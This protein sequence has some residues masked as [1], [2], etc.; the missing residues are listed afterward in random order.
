M[1]HPEPR[2]LG[3]GGEFSSAGNFEGLAAPGNRADEER[4]AFIG[5][6]D[7]FWL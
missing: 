5:H 4:A 6:H 3:D 7:P 1:S 2:Y